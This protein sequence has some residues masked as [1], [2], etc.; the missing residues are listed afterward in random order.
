M[1]N[2]RPLQDIAAATR[3]PVDAF[4]FVRRGLEYTVHRAHQNPDQ[5]DED[6]RHV[7]GRQLSEGLRDFAVQQ[8]GRMAR[9]VL[10][11]WNIHRCEDFGHIVFAMVEGGVMQATANDSVRDFIGVFDFDE[12]FDAPICVDR[13]PLEGFEPDTIE[14]V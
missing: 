7:N 12:A 14:Q 11:R 5:L 13:V 6:E 1:D 8:Y 10:Q 3:Y 9:T 4:H 2:Q